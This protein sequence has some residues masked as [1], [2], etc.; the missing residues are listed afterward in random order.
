MRSEILLCLLLAATTAIAVPG[1]PERVYHE[2]ARKA[3]NFRKR[4]CA[5]CMLRCYNPAAAEEYGR[6]DADEFNLPNVYDPTECPKLCTQGVP[7]H[8]QRKNGDGMPEIPSTNVFYPQRVQIGVFVGQYIQAMTCSEKDYS[9]R[10]RALPPQPVPDR[11]KPEAP[12]K[13]E[14]LFGTVRRRKKAYG[15]LPDSSPMDMP[16]AQFHQSDQSS[17]TAQTS[18]GGFSMPDWSD[19]WRRIQTFKLDLPGPRA[20]PVPLPRLKP[21]IHK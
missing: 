17:A 20:H 19:L 9:P 18:I 7:S 10:S 15:N 8:V 4:Y 11:V 1:D 13:P 6:M 21:G 16:S 12:E 3:G 2:A 5:E 14:E